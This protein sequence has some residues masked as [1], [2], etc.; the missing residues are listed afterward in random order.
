MNNYKQFINN[1]INK[2]SLPSNDLEQ[3]NVQKNVQKSNLYDPYEG[4]IRG[5][6]FKNLYDPYKLR[7]P[8]EIK[9]MNQQAEML[10]YID[11]LCFACVDLSLYLDTHPNDK[12]A[13]ETFNKY[14]SEK[15][16][17]VKRYESQFGPLT[18]DSESLNS[19][20]WSWNDRPWPWE[21]N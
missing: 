15:E 13:I 19:Y 7:Q 12:Q 16:T 5:N 9:P 18:L 17:L 4:L 2:F 14:R 11:A 10:T 8:Y 21:G 1:Y 6:M 3:P 20:P